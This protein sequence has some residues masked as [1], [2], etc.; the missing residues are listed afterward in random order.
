MSD[1][2]VDARPH[3]P[4]PRARASTAYS[5]QYCIRFLQHAYSVRVWDLQFYGKFDLGPE[6]WKRTDTGTVELTERMMAG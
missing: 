4:P 3:L 2:T 6:E 1:I 5:H